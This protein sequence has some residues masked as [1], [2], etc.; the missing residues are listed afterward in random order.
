MVVIGRVGGNGGGGDELKWSLLLVVC[1]GR[2][3]IYSW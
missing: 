3:E 2:N 1:S